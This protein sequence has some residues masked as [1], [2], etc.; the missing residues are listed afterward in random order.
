MYIE[1]KLHIYIYILKY[2]TKHHSPQAARAWR[3]D[4]DFRSYTVGQTNVDICNTYM[5]TLRVIRR[6]MG[7]GRAVARKPTGKRL[8]MMGQCHAEL[9]YFIITWLSCFALPR[10]RYRYKY[11]YRYTYRYRY[12]Y[13]SRYRHRY[14]YRY[15]YRYR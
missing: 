12:R 14:R 7:G 8:K 15:R 11:K 4:F 13:R 2:R 3:F 1:C 9:F 6:L 5:T 10:Y